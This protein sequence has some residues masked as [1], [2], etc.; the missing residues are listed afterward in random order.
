MLLSEHLY[1]V[2]WA[3][4]LVDWHLL[5]TLPNVYVKDNQWLF[6]MWFRVE[7]MHYTFLS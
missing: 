2:F 4:S 3:I 7:I 6:F 1:Y 5:Q